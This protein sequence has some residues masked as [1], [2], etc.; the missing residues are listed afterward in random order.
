MELK[1]V[2]LSSLGNGV[3]VERFNNALAK[4][5]EN[6]LD[7]DTPEKFAR[8]VVLTIKMKP[9]NADRDSLNYE[10]SVETKLS[11][12]KSHSG[13][14]YVGKEKGSFVAYETN[15]PNQ[16]SLLEVNEEGE[17]A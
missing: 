15:N 2:E 4:A 7:V 5:I 11:S 13:V 8:K 3:V 10:F 9:M 1:Q 16:L 12:P 6:V 17:I 14:M